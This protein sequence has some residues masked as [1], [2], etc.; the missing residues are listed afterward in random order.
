MHLIV[1]TRLLD[2]TVWQPICHQ[3]QDHKNSFTFKYLCI[4]PVNS[5][6]KASTLALWTTRMEAPAPMPL[7]TYLAKIE[8]PRRAGYA[9]RHNLQ[10]MLVIAI[11]AAL[12]DVDSF[13]D[14][15]FWASQK[16][17][18]LRRFLKL[19]NGI[20]AHDTFNRVFRLLDPKRFEDAFR[21]WVSGIV[22]ARWRWMAR[23]SVVRAMAPP[24]P[25]T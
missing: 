12:P 1:I 24:G 22:P 3:S 19:E 21:R 18:W 20:P 13:E 2:M 16:E 10:E 6:R 25:S 23:R 15:A 9:H 17:A 5:A 8:D 14:I 4:H 7:M 11:C